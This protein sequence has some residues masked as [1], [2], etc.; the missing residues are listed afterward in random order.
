[1]WCHLNVILGKI[2]TFGIS[3]DDNGIYE[4]QDNDDYHVILH[5][6]FQTGVF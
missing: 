6:G 5:P 1:M 4:K 2:I 3:A